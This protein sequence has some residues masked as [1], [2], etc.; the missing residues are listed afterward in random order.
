MPPLTNAV[1]LIDRERFYVPAGKLRK[2]IT[3]HQSLGRDIQNLILTAL[4]LQL[5][6]A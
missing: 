3:T 1:R 5:A 2:K 4:K 6:L